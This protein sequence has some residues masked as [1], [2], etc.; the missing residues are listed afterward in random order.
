MFTNSKKPAVKVVVK[1]INK[2]KY[3]S[4]CDPPPTILN[5]SYTKEVASSYFIDDIIGYK[6][7]FGPDNYTGSIK[8]G[9]NGWN[10]EPNCPVK[11][12][13]NANL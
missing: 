8:C 4:G 1:L 7:D 10:D 6:C 9:E 11:A 12:S 2:Q 3:L 5:G 13:G